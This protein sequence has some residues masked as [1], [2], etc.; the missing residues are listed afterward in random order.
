MSCESRR[1]FGARTFEAKSDFLISFFLC[2]IKCPVFGQGVYSLT[3]AILKDMVFRSGTFYYIKEG[4]EIKCKREHR[5]KQKNASM[6]QE[7]VFVK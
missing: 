2:L 6:A 3:A 1:H 4:G 5:N 7:V